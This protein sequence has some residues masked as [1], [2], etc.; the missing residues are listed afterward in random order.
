MCSQ[1]NVSQL[2]SNIRSQ[3]ISHA[4]LVLQGALTQPRWENSS[5]FFPYIYFYFVSIETALSPGTQTHLIFFSLFCLLNFVGAPS[6][7]L[8]WYLTCCVGIFRMALFRSWC[9]S[10]IRKR[11]CSDRW[12]ARPSRFDDQ[13]AVL[14]H[15]TLCW[16]HSLWIEIE[17]VPVC[18]LYLEISVLIHLSRRKINE[19]SL[20]QNIVRTQKIVIVNIKCIPLYN[21]SLLQAWYGETNHET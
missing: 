21:S 3:C 8:C 1:P 18:S 13:F 9:A 7:S 20:H 6:N 5:T 4:A 10:P 16:N 17:S 2:L 11:K 14:I 12:A 15:L 19:P